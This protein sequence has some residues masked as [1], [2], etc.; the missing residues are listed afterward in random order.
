MDL[1]ALQTSQHWHGTTKQRNNNI[2]II[3][4]RLITRAMS[5]YMTESE[6]RTVA[7]WDVGSCLR[8]VHKTKQVDFEPVFECCTVGA[9]LMAAGISFQILGAQ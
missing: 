5:E 4:H 8:M 9:F 3:I 7:R 2:I 6:A 1:P